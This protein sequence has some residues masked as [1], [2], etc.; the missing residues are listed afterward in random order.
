M[1][2][3]ALVEFADLEDNN[4]VYKK[5][6]SYPRKG[7]T[8]SEERLDLLSSK[9]NAQKKALIEDVTLDKKK[10][11]QVVKEPVEKKPTAKPVEPEAPKEAGENKPSK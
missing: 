4:R 10:A 1:T 8:V 2:Y 9:K 11:E 7:L 6:E 5:G 3:K